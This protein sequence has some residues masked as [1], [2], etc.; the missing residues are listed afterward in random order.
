MFGIF[1]ISIQNIK[2]FVRNLSSQKIVKIL[3][4]CIVGIYL[5][6]QCRST[7]LVGEIS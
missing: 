2:H 3:I 1:K 4:K 6:M 5:G 7:L